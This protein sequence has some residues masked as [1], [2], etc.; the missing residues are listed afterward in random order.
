MIEPP[1]ARDAAALTLAFLAGGAVAGLYLTALW[2][3]VRRVAHG[4]RGGGALVAGAIA[5]VTLVALAFALAARAGA[6][7]LAAAL[8]GFVAVRVL[9]TRRVRLGLGRGEG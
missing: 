8:V 1:T 3:S 7:P 5:R 6:A 2:R 4:P 9:V